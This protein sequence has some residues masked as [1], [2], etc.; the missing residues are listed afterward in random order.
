[1][2]GRGKIVV[3]VLILA[4]AGFGIWRWWDKIAPAGRS[5]NPSLDTAAVKKAMESKPAPDITSKLL[6]G[7][8]AVSLI[9]ESAIPPVAGTSDYDKTVKPDGKL[10]VQFPI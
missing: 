5:A 6:A 10:V 8:N 4:V 7:T 3:T 2:T 9:G 1:M